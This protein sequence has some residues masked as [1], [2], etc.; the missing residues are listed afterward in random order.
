MGFPKN[1][2]KFDI[3]MTYPWDMTKQIRDSINGWG[4][5][6]GENMYKPS[7]PMEQII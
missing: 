5:L 2:P 1:R 7:F 6:A 4:I 3:K